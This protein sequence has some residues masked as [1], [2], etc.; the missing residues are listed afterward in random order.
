M[1][2]TPSAPSPS[3]QAV[4][5]TF[6][7]M[8]PETGFMD[9]CMR[10]GDEVRPMMADEMGY[11]DDEL[12]ALFSRN[13]VIDSPEGPVAISANDWLS[14]HVAGAHALRARMAN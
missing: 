2:K 12:A 13:F 11:E 8:D 9:V 14:E 6:L 10:H 7:A 3:G 5:E 4:F 1:T